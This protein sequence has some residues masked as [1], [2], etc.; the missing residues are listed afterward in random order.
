MFKVRS[1]ETREVGAA[2]LAALDGSR[3]GIPSCSDFRAVQKELYDFLEVK[4]WSDVARSARSV[5]VERDADGITVQPERL[6]SG[7][8][9]EPD[10]T[11]IECSGTEVEHV[12]RAVIKGL[13]LSNET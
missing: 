9:F 8:S 5:A 4:R 12:G 10:G 2:V 6:A 13:R 3:C 1:L 11:V 7:A